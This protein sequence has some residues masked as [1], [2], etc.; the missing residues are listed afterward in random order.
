[1]R[2]GFLPPAGDNLQRIGK[3]IPGPVLFTSPSPGQQGF[4]GTPSVAFLG[5]SVAFRLAPGTPR[6]AFPNAGP[7]DLL[8][9]PLLLTFRRR[10][11]VSAGPAAILSVCHF[12]RWQGSFAPTHLPQPL[13]SFGLVPGNEEPCHFATTFQEGVAPT[14][15]WGPA[16]PLGW[17]SG[18][19]R[20]TLISR[21]NCSSFR[22]NR[23]GSNKTSFGHALMRLDDQDR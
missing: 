8:S 1:M 12:A 4:W 23:Q 19:P 9:D 21:A 14:N 22:T 18:F 15:A 11:P 16:Y 7:R 6:R 3:E 17:Q 20:P 5:R 13:D 2:L 10:K